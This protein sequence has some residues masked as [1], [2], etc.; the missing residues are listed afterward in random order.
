MPIL[1]RSWGWSYD[2]H[3]RFV[4]FP[5]S[6]S[7]NINNNYNGNMRRQLPPPR[8]FILSIY[9]CFL[10]LL[11]LPCCLRLV[12]SSP[13]IG[14]DR[15]TALIVLIAFPDHKDRLLPDRSYF[16]NVCETRITDYL[17]KQSYGQYQLK[18]CHVTEWMTTNGTESFYADGVANRKSPELAAAFAVPVLDQLADAVSGSI[19]DWSI[20]DADGD[21]ALD[22]VICTY[23]TP[24]QIYDK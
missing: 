8:R 5:T 23:H 15:F 21:G 13:S 4:C 10:L 3:Q 17:S 22:A 2:R 18:G 24:Q 9:L 14:V 20:Y 11:L 1:H 16:Q 6:K 7:N 19:T 12:Q